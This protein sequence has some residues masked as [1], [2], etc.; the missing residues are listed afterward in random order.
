MFLLS[1]IVSFFVVADTL[2]KLYLLTAVMR[3]VGG[4]T[5][6]EGRVEVRINGQWS[7]VYDANWEDKDAAV[8]CRHLGYNW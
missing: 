4:S 7:S 1:A 6:R 5:P 2:I 8:V 3:L